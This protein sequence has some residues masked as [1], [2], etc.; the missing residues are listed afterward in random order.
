LFSFQE[1][2][3]LQYD[4]Q[5]GKLKADLFFADG[6]GRS[7][8]YTI[9]ASYTVKDSKITVQKYRVSPKYMPAENVVCFVLPANEFKRLDK[10]SLPVSFYAMYKYA[11][12][13]AVTRQQALTYKDAKE[14]ALIVFLL[15]RVPE[16][17]EMELKL[18]SRKE[19]L[20]KG[21]EDFSRYMNYN[22][23]RVGV[24]GKFHL[25]QPDS[26]APLYA[27]VL[28]SPGNE[29]GSFFSSF[30]KEMLGLYKL[31]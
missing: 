17:A 7:C 25:L 18:S 5:A 31:R 12:A 15:E 1:A 10:P 29:S 26:N 23:W 30:S 19:K 13:S 8:A 9:D 2:V 16:S 6:L 22:G 4:K 11:A 27:K 21:Y 28:Y 14:W 20:A 24:L 3:L